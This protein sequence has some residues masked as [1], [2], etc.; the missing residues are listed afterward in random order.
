MSQAP[1]PSSPITRTDNLHHLL[2]PS[3]FLSPYILVVSKHH[4]IFPLADFFIPLI[5]PL[6]PFTGTFARDI[7]T[8]LSLA[9]GERPCPGPLLTEPFPTKRRYCRAEDMP[10]EVQTATLRPL[11][12]YYYSDPGISCPNGPETTSRDRRGFFL[13]A[14]LPAV[15]VRYLGLKG[16]L[17]VLV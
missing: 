17:G 8:V 2:L 11:L 10:L 14:M 15:N 12:E 5:S 9:P 7:T 6:P 3:F 13:W 1:H 4:E 16:G